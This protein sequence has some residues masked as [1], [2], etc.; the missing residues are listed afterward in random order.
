MGQERR[1]AAHSTRV[2]LVVL[3]QGTEGQPPPAAGT[4]CF[5]VLLLRRA[6]PAL[7]APG[8]HG[9]GS[10]SAPAAMVRTAFVFSATG[11]SVPYTTSLSASSLL[12]QLL[13][14]TRSC[15]RAAGIAHTQH[16]SNFPHTY[17]LTP[18]FSKYIH[19]QVQATPGHFQHAKLELAGNKRWCK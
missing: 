7:T 10:T 5:A 15:R 19:S 6:H 9:Q 8:V 3:C 2:P 1:R 14:A 17:L 11:M 4:A 16:K 18:K 13:M 12:P